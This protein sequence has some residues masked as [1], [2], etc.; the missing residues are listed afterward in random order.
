MV[1]KPF[2]KSKSS[3]ENEITYATEQKGHIQEESFKI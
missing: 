2:E 1:D 3:V